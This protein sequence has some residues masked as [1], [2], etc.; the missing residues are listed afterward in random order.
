MPWKR[1]LLCTVLVG[2]SDYKRI[3]AIANED[4]S[5]STVRTSAASMNSAW[6]TAEFSGDPS[7]AG[8]DLDYEMDISSETTAFGV[9]DK[10][11]SQKFANDVV[12]KKGTFH[13]TMRFKLTIWLIILMVVTLGVIY[14]LDQAKEMRL[15]IFGADDAEDLVTYNGTEYATRDYVLQIV[16]RDQLSS[17]KHWLVDQRLSIL[18]IALF[19]LYGLVGG[20]ISYWLMLLRS[21]GAMAPTTAGGLGSP[22]VRLPLAMI[23]GCVSYLVLNLASGLALNVEAL[24]WNAGDNVVKRQ[25]GFIGSFSVLPVLSGLFIDTFYLEMRKLLSIILQWVKQWI[26]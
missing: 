3:R 24:V 15:D 14:I 17:W 23:T 1:R 6:I 7:N 2:N 8:H 5:D 26:C 22:W 21:G 12:R 20:I 19:G 11:N 25:H 10:F 4:G 18:W 13:M 16:A 9:I